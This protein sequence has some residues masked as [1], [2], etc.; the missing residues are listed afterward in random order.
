MS[1]QSLSALPYRNHDKSGGRMFADNDIF[2][3]SNDWNSDNRT[4][5]HHI[6]EQLSKY[7]RVFYL[8]T[9]GLRAPRA[10]ARD[11]K[12]IF[13]KLL[14]GIQ[15]TR[16]VNDR[17]YLLTLL[18]VPLH[19]FGPVRRLNRF[20]LGYTLRRVCKKHQ[21]IQPVMWLISPHNFP[22]LGQLNELMTVYYC[23]DDFSSFPGVEREAIQLLDKRLAERADIVFAVAE[24]VW[25]QKKALN[26]NC[27][28]SPHG[29]DFDHFIKATDPH[30]PIPEEMLNLKKPVI[31]YI[32]VVEEWID[33]DLIEFMAKERPTWSFALIG[34]IA[35][36]VSPLASLP[37]VYLFGPRP[38]AKLPGYAKA[39]DVA[40]IPY[41]LNSQTINA[42]P[43]KLREYLASGKAVVSV[44]T[45]EV[46]RFKE[47]VEIAESSSEFLEK[48]EGCLKSEGRTAVEKR[49]RAV[50]NMGWEKHFEKLSVELERVIENKKDTEVKR[51]QASGVRQ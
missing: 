25:K 51:D 23:V 9:A 38:Y 40:I 34:R 5:S 19:R 36:D 30:L 20:L 32:G 3:F 49:L 1:A 28:F 35:V 15:G 11:I 47:V 12:R 4:S 39:F 13:L 29:V 16:R 7:N 26:E 48:I 8:E 21:V 6:A 37:N 43:K 31:G 2:Y 33:L 44:R 45:P 42:N 27:H 14:R 17:F 41:K 50:R 18:Q 10:N 46:E 24:T 22:V